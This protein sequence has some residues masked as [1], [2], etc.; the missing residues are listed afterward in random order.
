VSQSISPAKNHLPLTI[1]ALGVVFGDIGTSPLYALREC[2]SGSH[3]VALTEVNILGVLSLILWSLIFV[4]SIKY[5]LFVM[6]ADNKGEGGI[7]SLMSLLT[8]KQTKVKKYIPPVIA[9]G[10]M[11][12]VLLY[13]D[14]IITPAI[15]IL[16]AIEG[17]KI[18]TPLFEPYILLI[19][20]II[21]FLLFFFQH[22]GTASIGKVF[23][24][25]ILLWFLTL[26]VMGV[27]GIVN[28][29][30][31][32][33]A[34]NPI[35]GF[36]F[37]FQ[38]GFQGFVVLG[39]V[40]LVVTG[41][42]ALYADMGHFGLT[43]IRLGWFYVALP[44]LMLNYFGQ[45]A[46]LLADPT[47]I[48]NPFYALAP[49]WLLYP[50]VAL[51]TAAAVIASQALITGAFSLTQQAIHL[52]F[53][54]RLQVRHTSA[55][56]RGQI[57]IPFVNWALMIGTI[58]VVLMFKSSSALA[59]AYGI[60]VTGTMA[61][62]TILTCL[63]AY[64]IWRWSLASVVILGSA[65]MVV[66]LAFLGAN[67]LK[68]AQGGWFPLLLGAVLFVLMTTWKR[69][70]Q[71]LTNRLVLSAKPIERFVA[72]TVPLAKFRVPGVAVIMTGR[73]EGTPPALIHNYKINNVIHEYVLLL[74]IAT[75][76]VAHTNLE[77][78]LTIESLGANFYRVIA[79]YGFMDS[80]NAIDVLK[81][82]RSMGIPVDPATA[83]YILGRETL[84]ATD[85]PGM[86]L[87]REHLFSF[88]TR[89][90]QGAMAY[91]HLPP[92]QVI[93]IGLQIRI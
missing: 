47:A 39:C 25:I 92:K 81:I 9:L 29:L 89:N 75:D 70:R 62:T 44:A 58:F 56:E 72:E 61:I 80:P 38:N 67:V 55:S 10:L 43:P 76:D 42:E 84:I 36:E 77:Q 46:L 54:P 45:G 13:G 85:L 22:K 11:G 65:F 51:S 21:I 68:I 17:L 82:C 23:G 34:L 71:I 63:V 78:Q 19:S 33:A 35:L 64:K 69:G 12:A 7:L 53:L 30:G 26:A 14:G 31:V 60:A 1:A 8:P 6:R 16:S 59:S 27:S 93:E 2:F 49:N 57:Y 3:G 73:S 18:V 90:A 66:D 79:K 41:G 4:I 74:T 32:F 86:A 91:F 5:L 15:T 83:F 40:F 28:N 88:M 24:P 48:S 37:L 52:G 50:L 20:V 87:W